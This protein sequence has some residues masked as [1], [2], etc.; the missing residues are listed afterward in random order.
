MTDTPSEIIHATTVAWQRR[1]VVIAGPSGSGKSAM[2]LELMALGCSLVADDRTLLSIQSGILRAE[3][4]D[5]IRGRIEIRGAG[6][7][8]AEAAGR[9]PVTLIVDLS[10]DERERLP[11]RRVRTYLGI[12]IPC[13]HRIEGA[14]F[15]AAILHVLRSE[16]LD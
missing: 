11:P 13:L 8:A 15:P 14:H 2:A 4:P 12:P 16:R 1:A 9:I 6:I 10:T 3:A 5:P 7:F